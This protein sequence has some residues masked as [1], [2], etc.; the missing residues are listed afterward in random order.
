MNSVSCEKV[1]GG[2]CENIHSNIRCLSSNSMTT[3][4]LNR[5][6]LSPTLT[7]PQRTI[8]ARPLD[9][10]DEQLYIKKLSLART[11]RIAGGINLESY[12]KAIF[13]L[14]GISN[15]LID[16]DS[17]SSTVEEYEKKIE[18][19]ENL[20]VPSD[21]NDTIKPIIVE[22]KDELIDI[23]DEIDLHN[24]DKS[25]P[26][27]IESSSTSSLNETQDTSN[28]HTPQLPI[29]NRS[30]DISEIEVQEKPSE[31]PTN[32]ENSINEAN[33]SPSNSQ[34]KPSFTSRVWTGVCQTTTFLSKKV[35]QGLVF[36]V[37]GLK[38]ISIVV[39]NKFFGATSL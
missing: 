19:P 12:S 14:N 30:T 21:Q 18:N 33:L 32:F 7:R 8:R 20:L 4:C 17:D 28:S 37:E 25:T 13:V 15:T 1:S 23:S 6:W 27:H 22:Q 26:A 29:L 38:K 39:W 9:D 16:N 2:S 10:D 36:L 3:F 11:E 34:G 35:Y 5:N 24:R 31:N